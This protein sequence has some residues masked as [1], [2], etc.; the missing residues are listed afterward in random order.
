ML[1]TESAV[2]KAKSGSSRGV[3]QDMA[4]AQTTLLTPAVK[5]TICRALSTAN[6][7]TTA[8]ALAGIGERTFHDWMGRGEVEERGIYR[9]FVRAVS[10]ARACAK[11]NLVRQITRAAEHDW[12]AA[13]WKL[14]R[15]YPQ[16]YGAT[17]Q[18]PITRV[19]GDCSGPA[20]KITYNTGGKTMEELLDFPTKGDLSLPPNPFLSPELPR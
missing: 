11:A 14:E 10:H 1:A 19:E 7:V 17:A 5:T 15:L 18:R 9:S 13:A 12:R 16:E 2:E 4:K 20:I 8:C 3:Q 6:T